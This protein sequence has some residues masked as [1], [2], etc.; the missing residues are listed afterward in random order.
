MIV[1]RPPPA[2]LSS[3]CQLFLLLLFLLPRAHAQEVKQLVYPSVAVIVIVVVGTKI[4][5]S[6][7][8]GICACYKHNRSI[9]IGENFICAS[10]CSK[11]LTSATIR[12]F[13]VQH[14]C[15]L[16]TH[17][18]LA[19]YADAIAHAQAQCWKGSSNHKNSSATE[20]GG[21]QRTTLALQWLQ[22]TRGI[23]VLYRAL[24]FY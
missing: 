24:V 11:R 21:G 9:D 23:Y 10:S 12:A 7:L 5:I 18:L 8:L 20:Y 22:I 6:H 1:S 17:T 3:R 14:A 16:T 13:S 19:Y 2:C 15:N 4:T